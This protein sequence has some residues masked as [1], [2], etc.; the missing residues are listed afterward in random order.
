MRPITSHMTSAGF[1]RRAPRPA[2]E[3]DA[4][5]VVCRVCWAHV[6]LDAAGVEVVDGRAYYRC[7]ECGGSFLIRW[8][9]AVRLGCVDE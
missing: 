9:D 3:V 2:D 1:E 6:E 7:P 5:G 8:S 4:I